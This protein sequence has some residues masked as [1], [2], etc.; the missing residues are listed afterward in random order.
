MENAVAISLL[1]S[2]FQFWFLY[3][4]FKTLDQIFNFIIFNFRF[5]NVDHNFDISSINILGHNI[6]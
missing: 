3:S 2:G 1:E 4:K 6:S 5:Q